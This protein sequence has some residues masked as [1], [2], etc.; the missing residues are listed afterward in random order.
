MIPGV[1]EG[2]PLTER[3]H[4]SNPTLDFYER[5]LQQEAAQ[6]AANQPQERLVRRQGR[7]V[8]LSQ[9]TQP[10]QRNVFLPRG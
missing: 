5:A 10:I 9:V 4:T 8:P 6:L 2:S 7:M 3:G 1:M